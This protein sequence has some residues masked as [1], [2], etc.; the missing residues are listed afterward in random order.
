MTLRLLLRG[1]DIEITEIGLWR[2]RL[3]IKDFLKAT[4]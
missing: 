2:G 1:F 4:V 3:Q